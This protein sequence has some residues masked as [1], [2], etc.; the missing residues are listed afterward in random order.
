MMDGSTISDF[1]KRTSKLLVC[2]MNVDKSESAFLTIAGREAGDGLVCPPLV[3]IIIV[4]RNYAEYVGEAIN[5]VRRQSYPSI[6]CVVV[7]DASTDHSKA[8]IQRHIDNDPRFSLMSLPDNVGQLNAVLHVLPQLRGNFVAFVDS[9]DILYPDFISLHVQAHLALPSP[10]ALTSSDVIETDAAGHVHV[11]GRHGFAEGCD[12]FPRGLKPIET[13]MRIKCISDAEYVALSTATI[14]VP[15]YNTR[16]VWAPGTANVYR[17]PIIDGLIPTGSMTNKDYSVDGYFNL[18]THLMTGSALILRQ[19][20][21]Y[22]HHG[23][24]IFSNRPLLQGI[25]QGREGQREKDVT[26]RM[27]VLKTLTMRSKDFNQVLA[28]NRYWETLDLLCGIS[29]MTRQD[30]YGQ[31]EAQ[32]VLIEALPSLV[33]TFGPHETIARLCERMRPAVAWSVLRSANLRQS[34]VD[35]GRYFTIAQWQ[36]LCRW[37]F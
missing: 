36:R 4:N 15:H 18:L 24:N 22:R 16:W 1:A 31:P 8:V 34:A 35:R 5:S 19:L 25:Q 2:K 11:S 3:S 30:Y 13:A 32:A 7:D 17:K 26:R 21:T 20:S 10:V 28:G 37:T 9:D 33:E 6:E 14:S 27:L 23:R 29:D 12:G